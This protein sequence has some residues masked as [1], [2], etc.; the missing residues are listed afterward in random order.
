MPIWSWLNKHWHAW[1][2]RFFP[3]LSLGQKGERLAARY[4]RR[5]GYLIIARGERDRYAEID[6]IAVE[7]RTV[8]FV[9]VK[10]RTHQQAGHPAEAVDRDKQRRM[11]R[12]ALV[13]RNRHDLHAVSMRFDVV[14]ITWPA[15]KRPPV[16]EH[17]VNAFQAVE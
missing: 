6:L 17:F 10:T 16:I 14:A 3:P 1:R 15:D 5:K 11:T 8:V 4:L 7:G 2:E 13:Y 12:A 9:E